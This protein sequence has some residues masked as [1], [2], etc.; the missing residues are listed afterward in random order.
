M[1]V[2]HIRNFISM[3][4]KLS[5]KSYKTFLLKMII[6]TYKL[7][8]VCKL[9]VKII[10]YILLDLYKIYYLLISNLFRLMIFTKL[11]F[12]KCNFLK[13]RFHT[14]PPSRD[15]TVRYVIGS[16]PILTLSD[17]FWVH[18][19]GEPETNIMQVNLYL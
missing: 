17:Y 12:S 5:K 1:K 9:Y 10:M 19:V 15:L 14:S 8:S 16:A 3:P 13:G 18:Q 6:F 4:K 2:F 7:H 11:D